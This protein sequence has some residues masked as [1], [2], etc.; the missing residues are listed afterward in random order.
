[1][2]FRDGDE[3][4]DAMVGG[5]LGG[6]EKYTNRQWSSGSRAAWPIGCPCLQFHEHSIEDSFLQYPMACSLTAHPAGRAYAAASPG[7]AKL[8]GET[9]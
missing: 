1:M 6:W 3:E 9:V 7:T 8:G 4:E 5:G 2:I